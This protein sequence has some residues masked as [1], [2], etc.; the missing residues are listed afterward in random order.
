MNLCEE[1]TLKPLPVADADAVPHIDKLG[2][3]PPLVNVRLTL[4]NLKQSL[5]S[6]PVRLAT[7]HIRVDSQEF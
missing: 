7:D 3:H 1:N 4:A 6:A 5:F 2:S